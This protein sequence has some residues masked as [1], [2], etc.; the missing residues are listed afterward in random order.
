[1]R[2]WAVAWALALARRCAPKRSVVKPPGAP[3]P[4]GADPRTRAAVAA[5]SASRRAEQRARGEL[6]RSTLVTNDTIGAPVS[7]LRPPTRAM[8]LRRCL[9]RLSARDGDGPEERRRKELS[10]APCAVGA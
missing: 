7:R 6:D 10:L 1:M 3:L 5:R 4:K 8:P 9:L 2:V